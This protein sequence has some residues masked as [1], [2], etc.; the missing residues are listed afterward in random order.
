MKQKTS[1]FIDVTADIC[2]ITSVKV[3]LKL[4]SMG[5]G[6]LLEVK[7]CGAETRMNIARSANEDKHKVIS[8]KPINNN[9]NAFLLL[10]EKC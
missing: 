5:V 4:E 8:V 1:Q 3:K 9:S 6:E 10:I 2:P 7:L